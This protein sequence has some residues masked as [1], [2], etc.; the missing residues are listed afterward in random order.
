[1][2]FHL[3]KHVGHGK[4][5]KSMIPADLL[6][7]QKQ[8]FGLNLNDKF[9]SHVILLCYPPFS[10]TS[11]VFR[12]MLLAA[13][14]VIRSLLKNVQIKSVSLYIFFTRK[15]MKTWQ[16]IALFFFN[17]GHKVRTIVGHTLKSLR[18]LKLTLFHPVGRFKKNYFKLIT[19][20]PEMF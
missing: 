10:C 12:F 11:A 4:I 17:N 14:D 16:G 3:K 5:G 18:T 6:Q 20:I 15:H 19:I 7:K 13:G 2:T 9:Y 1:M 8:P